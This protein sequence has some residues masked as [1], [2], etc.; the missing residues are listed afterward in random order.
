MQLD[1]LKFT[2][3]VTIRR[4]NELTGALLEERIIKNLVV[5]SGLTWI[6]S[7]MT[8]GVSSVM[9]HMAVGSGNV[10][11][12]DADLALGNELTRVALVSA[13]AVGGVITYIASYPAGVGTGA[14]TEAGILNAAVAGTLLART[15]FPVVNKG[16]DDAISITWA[17]TAAKV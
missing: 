2:G 13:T 7:R 17:I 4:Y 1:K 14:L 3:E 6:T 5:S 16:V 10:A 11:A 8:E 12:A 15:V 9:S